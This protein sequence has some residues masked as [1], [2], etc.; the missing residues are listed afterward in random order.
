[1]RCRFVVRLVAWALSR[2]VGAS[3]AFRVG[4][5]KC[6]RDVVVKFNKVYF[7]FLCRFWLLYRC[8]RLSKDI[9]ISDF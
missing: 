3:V 8:I 6:L 5:W 2:V 1:M 9:I 7:I 4:G